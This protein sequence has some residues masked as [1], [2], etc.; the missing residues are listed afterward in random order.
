MMIDNNKSHFTFVIRTSMMLAF[1]I[2]TLGLL[3]KRPLPEITCVCL[4]DGTTEYKLLF[5]KID[6]E[7]REKN[8]DTLLT[9]L[10]TCD[11]IVGFN[12]VLFD[13]EFVK[14]TFGISDERMS[15]WVRK[16]VD[17]YMFLKFVS[18]NTS[19]MAPLLALNSMPSK[20]GSG[21]QAINLALDGKNEELLAYCLMDAKLVY[22]LCKLYEI[23]VTGGAVL[24]IDHLS[25]KWIFS[26]TKSSKKGF[27]KKISLPIPLVSGIL[28]NDVVTLKHVLFQELLI[29][30]EKYGWIC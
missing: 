2:E 25:G 19:A 11:R 9:L 29:D 13:L 26:D 24:R 4:F 23:K 14:Q 6:T 16:T 3:D 30:P 27:K 12:A 20:T 15:K 17:L 5:Y 10:D 7:Q 1:D 18:N 22:N 28:L 21:I 8:I